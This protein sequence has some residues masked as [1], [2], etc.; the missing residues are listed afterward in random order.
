MVPA[1]GT[2]LGAQDVEAELAYQCAFPSGPQ[3]VTVRV[4]GRFPDAVTRGQEIQPT[5]VTTTVE[6]PEAVIAELGAGPGPEVRGS[7]ELAV[8]LSQG[9]ARAEAVWRG[10]AAPVP[11]PSQGPLKLE[12]AGDVP[13][14]IPGNVGDLV[15]RAG[16]LK[17]ALQTTGAST[18]PSPSQ[19]PP[20]PV[21]ATCSPDEEAHRDSL[22]TTIP[23]NGENPSGEPPPSGAPSK[24]SEPDP[25]E[26][27]RPG[28]T[29]QR[30]RA[31][32][33]APTNAPSCIA[34][35]PTPMSL[36]AYVTGYSNVAKLDGASLIPLTCM[37][38]EQGD[39]YAVPAPD[40]PF[41]FF[42]R[43]PATARLDHRGSAQ[44]PPA[45]A[46]FLTFGFTPTTATM[47]LEQTG[48]IE[49]EGDIHLGDDAYVDTLIR[50]PLVLRL[51]DVVVNG[52][53]LDVGSDCRT[54]G[55]L[56]SE[57]PEPERFPGDHLVL[58]GTAEWNNGTP[59]GYFMLTGGPLTGTFSIP[60]FT[61]CRTSDGEDLSR[62]LTSSISGPGN[63][64]KQIQ[65]QTCAVAQPV[66][67]E[68][69]EDGQPVV[70]PEPER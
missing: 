12:S 25:A 15:L 29:P 16:T 47:T 39:S 33:A 70:I 45:K 6:L 31:G 34:D 30:P 26:L 56:A 53:P 48:P 3:P 49:I 7:T 42:L 58:G 13:S 5:D 1:T 59:R 35:E 18:S 64:V 38:V 50:A 44:T 41:G 40:E 61:D 57:E 11:L 65:G 62:L 23:V 20:D 37:Q 68:C 4:S 66:E 36:T 54:T 52:T 46:T 67:A 24:T 32:T 51:S 17:L 21:S 9:K 69:T 27:G 19:S 55:P 22:L 63:Y 60:A 43:Q 2:A 10:T 28:R 14:V 8:G